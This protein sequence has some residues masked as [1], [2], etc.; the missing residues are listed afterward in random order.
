MNKN[1]CSNRIQNYMDLLNNIY[2]G[3]PTIDKQTKRNCYT[4]KL[5]QQFLFVKG[6]NL[7]LKSVHFHCSFLFQSIRASSLLS[8]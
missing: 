1:I 5:V 7:S 2:I 6:F 4:K 8:A 3:K